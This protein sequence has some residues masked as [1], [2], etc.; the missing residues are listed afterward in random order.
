MNSHRDSVGYGTH[1]FDVINTISTSS[2]KMIAYFMFWGWKEKNK[3][4]IYTLQQIFL[5]VSEY[6]FIRTKKQN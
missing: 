3:T 6:K 4:E 5:A 1:D 2:Y